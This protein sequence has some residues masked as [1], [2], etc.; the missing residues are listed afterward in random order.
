MNAGSVVVIPWGGGE[1][2]TLPYAKKLFEIIALKCNG[3]T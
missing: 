1:I 3:D 2:Q